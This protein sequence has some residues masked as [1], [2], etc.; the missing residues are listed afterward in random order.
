VRKVGLQ[1]GRSDE[2][3]MWHDRRERVLG[4][5]LFGGAEEGAQ[6][7][8]KEL[9][10]FLGEDVAK[11]GIHDDGRDGLMVGPPL[12]P[13]FFEYHTSARGEFFRGKKNSYDGDMPEYIAH[14]NATSTAFLE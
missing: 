11:G 14:I 8:D 9:T 1:I 12:F 4:H 5:A 6:D 2:G 13:F 3:N 7:G 10:A